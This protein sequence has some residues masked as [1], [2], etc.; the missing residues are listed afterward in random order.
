MSL[1]IFQSVQSAD[2]HKFATF[3]QEYPEVKIRAGYCSTK[4]FRS[5]CPAAKTSIVANQSCKSHTPQPFTTGSWRVLDSIRGVD[6]QIEL[7]PSST[8]HHRTEAQGQAG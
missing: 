5:N 1:W 8:R 2:E 7:L 3:T 6:K 4:H